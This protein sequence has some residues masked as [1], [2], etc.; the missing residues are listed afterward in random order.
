MAR[1]V[2]EVI[3]ALSQEDLNAEVQ[4]QSIDEDGEV[5]QTSDLTEIDRDVG[6]CLVTLKGDLS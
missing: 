4:I 5:V 1:T 2:R 6:G 3:A